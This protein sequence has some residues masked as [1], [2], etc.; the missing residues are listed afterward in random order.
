M[1]EKQMDVE[2]GHTFDGIQEY[3]N[4]LPRWWLVIF[5]TTVIFGYGYWMHYHVA[6][7]GLSGAAAYEAEK[8][9][10]LRKAA[11]S[12]PM[13]DDL[14]LSMAKDPQTVS[15]GQKLF[16]QQ[17]AACHTENGSGKIGPNLTDD[18][19]LHGNKP[20]EILKTVSKGVVEKGMP[21]WEPT[22][23][24]ERVRN[25][26]AFVISNEGKNLPGKEPQGERLGIVK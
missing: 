3:D 23:G 15:T 21:A 16:V 19:W 6:R 7:T 14:L 2:R 25:I 10:A 5:Y 1:S 20:T 26:V 12:K 22:L 18:Y 11:A 8:A 13:S 17:C 4:P 9:E 24:A